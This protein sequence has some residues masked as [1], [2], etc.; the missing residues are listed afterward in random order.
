MPSSLGRGPLERL[1]IFAQIFTDSREKHHA[2][3]AA[4]RRHE[5]ALSKARP[6]GVCSCLSMVRGQCRSLKFIGDSE[7]SLD[8]RL[9]RIVKFL[10]PNG[11]RVP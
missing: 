10:H 7:Q 9:S 5:A 6:K 1:E 4:R 3:R 2:T 8:E 11:E